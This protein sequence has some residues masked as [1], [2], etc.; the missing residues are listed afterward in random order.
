TAVIR[1]SRQT[2]VSAPSTT[3]A[4]SSPERTTP[5]PVTAS[6]LT[7]CYP[8]NRVRPPR[9]DLGVGQYKWGRPP[10]GRGFRTG[11]RSTIGLFLAL[12]SEASVQA[13]AVGD[14]RDDDDL[15]GQ[16]RVRHPYLD[17]VVVAAHPD[18]VLVRERHVDDRT[19]SRDLRRRRDPR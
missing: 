16:R 8:Q 10:G 2:T 9:A 1:P 13:A 11:V 17:G 5:A 18:L 4:S 14:G 15:V 6:V 19:G 12:A 7:A 3:G